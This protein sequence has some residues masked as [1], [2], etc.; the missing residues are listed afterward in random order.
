[1][2]F[3]AAPTMVKRLTADPAVRGADLS[4]LKTIIYGGAPMYV[5]DASRAIDL[6]GPRLYQ[7]FGQGESPMTITGLP[8]PEHAA[9]TNLE[10]CGYART[11]VEVRV[12]DGEDRDLPPGEVGEILTRS[13]CVMAGYWRRPA[14][15]A[16]VLNYI[17]LSFGQSSTP[18]TFVPYTPEEVRDLRENRVDDPLALR[19]EIGARLQKAGLQLP[20]YEWD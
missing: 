11:A 18:Q 4:G 13:D 12:V 20:P 19:R 1:V 16:E 7:L 15:T 8:Q 6:F 3:F 5:A 9:R 14:E 2:S 10:T 17:L